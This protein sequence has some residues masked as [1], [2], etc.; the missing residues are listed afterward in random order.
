M[1]WAVRDG[2]S[3]QDGAGKVLD[4]LD[5]SLTAVRRN[6]KGETMTKSQTFVGATETRA[7]KMSRTARQIERGTSTFGVAANTGQRLT[8]SE[9]A[10]VTTKTAAEMVQAELVL[11]KGLGM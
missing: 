6:L 4:G 10:P 1:R 3:K 11:M 8:D 2:I 9:P 7:D 5:A